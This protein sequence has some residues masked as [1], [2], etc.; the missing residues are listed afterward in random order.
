[1]ASTCGSS[2]TSQGM[3]SALPPRRSIHAAHC[4][5]LASS[6]STQTTTAPASARP[7]AIP[8]PMLG[9]VPVTI[10][11]LPARRLMGGGAEYLL[12]DGLGDVLRLD[13]LGQVLLRVDLEQL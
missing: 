7:S 9:L 11:I 2:V 5:A 12:D 4:R 8:P 6:M 10:A 1:M 13:H 3:P